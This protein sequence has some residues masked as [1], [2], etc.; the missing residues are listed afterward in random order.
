VLTVEEYKSK[1]T[2]IQEMFDALCSS[3]PGEGSIEAEYHDSQHI[4]LRIIK[5]IPFLTFD[6]NH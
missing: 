3:D 2:E 4:E 1:Y 5:K 6:E